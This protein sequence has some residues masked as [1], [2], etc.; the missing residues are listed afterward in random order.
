MHVFAKCHLKNVLVKGSVVF[1]NSNKFSNMLQTSPSFMFVG[2]KRRLQR[3]DENIN[4]KVV[5][6]VYLDASC[7][8]Q[9]EQNLKEFKTVN[10]IIYEIE[11]II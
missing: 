7:V 4:F 3:N 10:R 2:K 9:E 1:L 6:V 11:E 8:Y 5:N